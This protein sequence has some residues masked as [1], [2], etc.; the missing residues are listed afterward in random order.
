MA[1]IIATRS[2]LWPWRMA[3]AFLAIISTALAAWLNA[4]TAKSGGDE[5]CR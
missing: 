3:W 5:N 1:W 4:A 2:Y